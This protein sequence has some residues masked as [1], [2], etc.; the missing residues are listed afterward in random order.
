MDDSPDVIGLLGYSYAVKGERTEALRLLAELQRISAQR[1]VSA[2]NFAWIQISLSQTNEALTSLEKAVE[3]RCRNMASLKIDPQWEPLRT[4]PRF[5][6][7]L[8]K[9]HLE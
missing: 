2:D 8:K 5:K 9:V 3:Q 1:Y 4:D 6:N 7:L